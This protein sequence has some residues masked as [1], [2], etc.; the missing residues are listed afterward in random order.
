MEVRTK[1][2][3]GI[4]IYQWHQE[5]GKDEVKKD[6]RTNDRS[7]SEK[8]GN[9][10]CHIFKRRKEIWENVAGAGMTQ[11]MDS[12]LEE[13]FNS[14]SDSGNYGWTCLETFLIDTIRGAAT[15]IWRVEAKMLLKTV[16][17]P[18]QSLTVRLT[19]SKTYL[20]NSATA[21]I[22]WHRRESTEFGRS[23]FWK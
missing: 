16:Q 17:C 12:Q 5:G 23:G 19:W 21:E 4:P 10:L 13:I 14:N 11:N 20:V 15:G 22:S 6:K 8:W 1:V 3:T 7:F 18:E 9:Q 2:S